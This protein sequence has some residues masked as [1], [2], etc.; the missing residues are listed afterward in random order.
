MNIRRRR[1][2]G[3][4]ELPPPMPPGPSAK[5]LTRAE[6]AALY[7]GVRISPHY[8]EGRPSK[9]WSDGQSDALCG[10]SPSENDAA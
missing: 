6:V 9:R 4:H 8:G 5:R 3:F 1:G 2:F 10:H 7:P